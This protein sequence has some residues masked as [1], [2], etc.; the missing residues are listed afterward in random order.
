MT[1]LS[2]PFYHLRDADLDPK[3]QAQLYPFVQAHAPHMEME[4][5]RE[6]NRDL[7]KHE[8]PVV[9]TKIGMKGIVDQ[10]KFLD[11]YYYTFLETVTRDSRGNIMDLD[12]DE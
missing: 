11:H 4:H 12:E 8:P 3:L 1:P 2:D 9:V 10:A 6:W 5:V 7:R